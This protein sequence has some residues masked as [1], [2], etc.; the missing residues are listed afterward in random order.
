MPKLIVTA[1]VVDVERWLDGKDDLIA[2]SAPFADQVTTYVA[3]DGSN[4]VAFTANV[5]DLAGLQAFMASPPPEVAEADKRHGI[6]PPS[7]A[8]IEK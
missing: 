4:N 2:M 5:H 6:I 7:T 3:M 1:K 8:Y